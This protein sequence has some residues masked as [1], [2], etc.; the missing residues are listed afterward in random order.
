MF[1][2]GNVVL[3]NIDVNKAIIAQY[4]LNKEEYEKDYSHYVYPL[5]DGTIDASLYF[6]HA[7][8]QFNLHMHPDSLSRFFE[9]TVNTEVV[10]IIKKLKR[11]GHMVVCAS[12][13][14]IDHYEKILKMGVIENF[15]YPFVS[16]EMGLCKPSRQFFEH[17]L[18]ATGFEA[19]NS[20]FIDDLYENVEASRKL[21]IKGIWF[22]EKDNKS[23]VSILNEELAAFGL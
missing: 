21:G 2:L 12:N 14:Y 20:F 4:N 22:Y 3:D 15:D 11:E 7:S 6:R 1:D 19:E 17:I 16:H 18:S 8:H 5:M 23:A 9:P 10:D 13:T